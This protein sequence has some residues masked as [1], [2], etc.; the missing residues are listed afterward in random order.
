MH[1]ARL[2]QGYTNVA[3]TFRR[4]MVGPLSCCEPASDYQGCFVGLLAKALSQ[5]SA[6]HTAWRMQDRE[7]V[8]DNWSHC[9][10]DL[11]ANENQEAPC[12]AC[13]IFLWQYF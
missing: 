13:Q 5:W 9:S 4:T 12:H 6:H 1:V 10:H 2:T 11:G 7:A 3:T 8:L